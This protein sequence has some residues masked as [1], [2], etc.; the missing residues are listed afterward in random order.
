MKNN[1]DLESHSKGDEIKAVLLPY[2]N[3]TKLIKCIHSFIH[4]MNL[5]LIM[6]PSVVCVSRIIII[7]KTCILLIGSLTIFI[8]IIIVIIIIPIITK[9]NITVRRLASYRF[10]FD[11]VFLDSRWDN[12]SV[13]GGSLLTGCYLLPVGEANVKN[14]ENSDMFYTLKLK[15]SVDYCNKNIQ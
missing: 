11:T 1:K 15:I 2:F 9:V 4:Q 12:N 14:R 13:F 8:I 10:V 7:I 6:C 3:D 5:D